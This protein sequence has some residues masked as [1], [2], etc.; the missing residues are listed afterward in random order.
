MNPSEVLNDAFRTLL[1]EFEAARDAIDQPDWSPPPGTD[2]NLADGYVYLLGHLSRLFET[3]LHQSPEHPQFQRAMGGMFAKYTID[4]ADTAYLIATI[5]PDREYI[6]RAELADAVPPRFFS[7]ASITARIGDTGELAELNDGTNTTVDSLTSLDHGVGTYGVFA[8]LVGPKPDPTWD[9][10]YL[11]TAGDMSAT[12]LAV[13]QVFSDWDTESPYR[14]Y[15]ET[16]DDPGRRGEPRT[17]ETVAAQLEDLGRQLR[18]QM[19]F[20]NALNVVLVD[21]QPTNGVNQPAPPFIAG[22][23]AGV[24]QFFGGGLF[25]LGP[26]EAL[27]LELT[28]R[29]EPRYGSITL[30]NLWSESLDQGRF[31]S[32]RTLDQ[33]DRSPNGKIY[34]VISDTDPGGRNWLDT[35]G[36][37]TGNLTSRF[38]FD[39]DIAGDERPTFESFVCSTEEAAELITGRGGAFPAMDPA[40]RAAE[41]AARKRHL[42]RRYPA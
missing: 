28:L 20:W 11:N 26:G 7:L 2:R 42:Q 39:G 16:R 29:T 21:A 1:A 9:G 22:G 35:T 24:A 41:R 38:I 4:N 34:F 32:S 3:V 40:A 25:D 27:V 19:R 12:T 37:R 15:L 33:C 5:D 10:P 31:T 17:P 18:N 6:M 36:L 8:V 14:L 30:G 23:T 13:R